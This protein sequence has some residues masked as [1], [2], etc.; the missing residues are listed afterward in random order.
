MFMNR[1]YEKRKTAAIE[2][3]ELRGWKLSN[4]RF[5]LETLK[6]RGRWDGKRPG[7]YSHDLID[8]AYYYRDGKA[9]A[10]IA[11]HL[12]DCRPDDLA[13]DRRLQG[14]TVSF[15]VVKSWWNPACTVVLYEPA[16]QESE[17]KNV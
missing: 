6:R 8:H 10:G 17:E 3:G 14:V 15:P 16:T 2:F 11:A 13:A 5:S 12:Y 9:A 1:D 7:D 4:C